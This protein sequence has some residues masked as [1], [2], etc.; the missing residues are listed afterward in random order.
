MRQRKATPLERRLPLIMCLLQRQVM[1]KS[2][3]T[4]KSTVNNLFLL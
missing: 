2:G 3:L 1:G 4:P